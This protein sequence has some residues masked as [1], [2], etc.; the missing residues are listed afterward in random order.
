MH[1][2]V[3]VSLDKK[4]EQGVLEHSILLKGLQTMMSHHPSD[5][6]NL[7]QVPDSSDAFLSF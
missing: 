7:G 4:D 1:A 3:L 2:K 6:I 5:F